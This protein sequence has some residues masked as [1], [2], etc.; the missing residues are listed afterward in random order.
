MSTV[1]RSCC[2]KPQQQSPTERHERARP[3]SSW[4]SCPR[5]RPQTP[6]DA[7]LGERRHR[8]G[9]RV[10]FLGVGRAPRSSCILGSC[11]TRLLFFSL[12]SCGSSVLVATDRSEGYDA[13]TR[14]KHQK[15]LVGRSCW[16]TAG[17]TGPLRGL[18]SRLGSRRRPGPRRRQRRQ[19]CGRGC[20]LLLYTYDV[21]DTRHD[22][23]MYLRL[24]DRLSACVPCTLAPQT[25][26][27][28]D[29]TCR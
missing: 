28:C 23:Y 24:L 5:S 16:S 6:D 25:S 26:T 27:H 1:P 9:G 20:V 15:G 19:R 10:R 13:F 17:P 14:S 3:R 29:D 8:G 7:V 4:Q 11:H 21:D 12:Q 18:G 22:K 2:T